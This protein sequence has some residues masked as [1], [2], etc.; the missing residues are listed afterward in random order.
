MSDE[1]KVVYVLSVRPS[2]CFPHSIR[3]PVLETPTQ[4][5]I[6][7]EKALSEISDDFESIGRTAAI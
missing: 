5:R 1:F 6:A 3:L 2:F 7:I 4:T